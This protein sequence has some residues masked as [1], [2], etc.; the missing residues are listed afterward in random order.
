MTDIR[1]PTLGESITEAT[2]GKWFKQPGDAVAVD[3]PLVE[4]E[5]DKVTLEVPAPAAGVLGD[6]AAKDGDTVGVGALLGQ[7]KDGAGAAAKPAA[8]ARGQAGRSAEAGA[9]AAPAAKA[10]RHAGAAIGAQNG[11]GKRRRSRQ[12]RR[13]RP[14]RPGHQRRHDGGDRARRVGADTGLTRRCRCGRRRR[15]MMHRAKSACT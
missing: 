3:E 14:A 12:G 1:V 5:T 8:A 10:A 4:L 2:V 7:I 11:G 13:L 6:I 9:R 15:P